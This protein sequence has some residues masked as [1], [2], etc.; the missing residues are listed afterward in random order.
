MIVAI[1]SD[2]V[3]HRFLFTV[4]PVF[5]AISGFA[6]LVAVHDNMHAQYAALFLAAMGCYSAMPVIL[7]WFNTNRKPHLCLYCRV[8]LTKEFSSWRAP[9][10]GGGHGVAGWVW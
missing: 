2:R 6:V 7:C 5:L 4:I 9:A 1:I 8:T 3:K 10:E